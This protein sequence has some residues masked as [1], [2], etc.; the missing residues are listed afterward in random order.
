MNSCAQI[1]APTGGK[2]DKEAPKPLKYEPLNGTTNFSSK[3]ISISF[4]EFIQLKDLNNQL[5]ISPPLQYIPDIKT[6]NKE[7]IIEFDKKEQLKPNTTYSISM[8]NAIQDI[9]ESTPI[10]NFSYHFSTGT[11]IDS[12]KISGKVE[13]AFDTKAEKS[14]LVMLYKNYTDSSTN[15]S[16]PDYIGKTKEDGTFEINNISAGTYK[17]IALKD[18]NANYKYDSDNEKI[19]FVDTLINVT[20]NP[21]NTIRLFE[22]PSK[23]TFIKYSAHNYFGKVLIVL[24]KP[25]ENITIK[26]VNT[27][28]NDKDIFIDFSK[29]KDSIHYWFRNIEKDSI[30]FQVNEGNTIIDTLAFKLIKKADAIKNSRNP[31]KFKLSNSPNK[32]QTIELNS[33]LVINFSHPIEP[34]TIEALKNKEIKLLID[35]VLYVNSKNLFYSTAQNS[36]FIIKEKNN[37]TEKAFMFKENS[38]YSLFIEPGTF[39]DI[40]GLSNDSIQLNFKTREEKQYGSIK[41]KLN[42]SN[43][44][45]NYIVQ[46]VDDK[47][48]I[49][50]ETYTT[51]TDA[52]YFQYL[53]PKS[54]KLKVICDNNANLKWDTGNLQKSV[55]PEKVIYN[56]ETITTKANWDLE[57]DWKISE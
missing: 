51:K 47:E 2:L 53:L 50:R 44:S 43:K 23:K 19:G 3:S 46:L 38:K 48:N 30:Y 52:I 27:P 22:E 37:N 24:N 5:I 6:K 29:N 13:S 11:T 26:P 16:L 54:Y 56:A 57:L 42:V 28:V 33:D 35:S 7:L 15:K 12:M 41:L 25:N 4:D 1:V 32:N 55:Q 21:K 45:K 40:F 39:T 10:T 36:G 8:G 31:L 34:S 49:I 20:Q 17:L 14:I 9:H 18:A